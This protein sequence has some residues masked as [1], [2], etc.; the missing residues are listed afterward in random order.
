MTR[1]KSPFPGWDPYLQGYWRDVH[2]SMVVYTRDY[3]RA[4][5]PADLR[6]RVEERVFLE[7]EDDGV[8][9]SGSYVPDVS[10]IEWPRP[11]SG[12]TT[13]IEQ[14]VA[15]PLKIRYPFEPLTE[16]YIEIR[17]A[18][19][20]GRLVTSIEFTSPTNKAPGKGADSFRKKQQ[21]CR[22]AN[23]SVVEIDLIRGGEHILM[24]PVER[25]PLNRRDPPFACVFEAWNQI[26]L[27]FYA[28]SIQQRLP[29]IRIPLRQ[30]DK[31][32]RLDIQAIFDQAY[33]NGDYGADIDYSVD[34]DVSLTPD[35]RQWLDAHL[36][37]QG[38]R[39]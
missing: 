21:D 35:E 33:L 11:R 1:E 32:A 38:L 10:V 17:D 31:Q 18:S 34:P 19:S 6:V 23:V 36:R 16:G 5:L 25:I 24:V 14:A 39:K 26:D 4:Q 27:L 37:A 12:A 8:P 22:N 29:A 20:G 15:E 2:Q 30:T 13:T 7:A 28:I 3:L 9:R